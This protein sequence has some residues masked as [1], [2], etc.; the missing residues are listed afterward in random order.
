M[1]GPNVSKMTMTRGARKTATKCC[2]KNFLRRL[3]GE[4][5]LARRRARRTGKIVQ[6][7]DW[8]F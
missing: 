6:I 7:T 5:V 8:W 3:S 2:S 1:K 4:K